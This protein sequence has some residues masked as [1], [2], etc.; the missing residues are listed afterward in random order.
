LTVNE[1]EQKY[2]NLEKRV[3]KIEDDL[4]AKDRRNSRFF[5]LVRESLEESNQGI[6]THIPRGDLG[7]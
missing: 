6:E 2:K 4:H 1:L 5:A 3:L 7:E